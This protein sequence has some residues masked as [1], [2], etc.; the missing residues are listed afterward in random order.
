[1]TA[2][3]IFSPD[4]YAATRR[5]LHRSLVQ[6]QKRT[7]GAHAKADKAREK[8]QTDFENARIKAQA[9]FDQK[10]QDLQKRTGVDHGPWLAPSWPLA[11]QK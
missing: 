4:T 11:R 7:E 2:D 1:M 8:F 5:P 9:G 10:I 3:A 6:L